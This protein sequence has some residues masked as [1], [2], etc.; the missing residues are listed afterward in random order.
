MKYSTGISLLIIVGVIACAKEKA[1]PSKL[2]D[3]NLFSYITDTSGYVYYQNANVLSAAG[4]SPHGSFKMRFNNKAQQLL[5]SSLELPS[6]ELFPDSSVIVKEVT[7]GTNITLYAVMFKYN[8]T[9]LW[10]EYGPSGNILHGIGQGSAVC[11]QCHNL[12]PNRDNVLS[13]DLH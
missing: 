6:G 12:S 10:A 9:W 1:R 3:E 8:G 5:N 4:N 13:F 11:L 7:N 2:L